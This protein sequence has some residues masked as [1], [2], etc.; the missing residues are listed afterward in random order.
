MAQDVAGQDLVDFIVARNRL[1]FS[2][3]RIAIDVVTATVADQHT[4]GRQQ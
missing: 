1:H 3:G 4:A 2:G